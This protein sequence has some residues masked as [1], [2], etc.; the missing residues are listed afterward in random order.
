MAW[1]LPQYLLISAGEVMFSIT[2]LA[3][4]YSQVLHKDKGLTIRLQDL[5]LHLSLICHTSFDMTLTN[6]VIYPSAE[7]GIIAQLAGCPQAKL[8]RILK[9]PV[10]SDTWKYP[11]LVNLRTQNRT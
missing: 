9:V 4:S 8:I 7:R 11:F 5:F 2:G 3:F 6:N 10:L 1:Q